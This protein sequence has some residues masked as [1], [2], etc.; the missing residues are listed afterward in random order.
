MATSDTHD[1]LLLP[2][3]LCNDAVWSEQVRLL[4]SLRCHIPDYGK[5]DSIKAMAE[6]VLNQA[7]ARFLLAGHSMGGRVALEIY[8]QAP[9]RV[10]RLILLDTGFRSRPTDETGEREERARMALLGQAREQGMR[11]MGTAWLQGMVHP[12]RLSDEPLLASILNMIESKTPS[13]FAAQIQALLTRPEATPVLKNIQCPTLLICGRQDS[14]S[15]LSR[16]EEMAHLIPDS[17]LVVIEEAGHMSPMERPIEVASAIQN[18]LTE[19][20]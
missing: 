4:P 20:Q 3:L 8:R 14:W 10:S 1:L 16:H 18:W 11:A 15:P 5:A 6:L 2:G 12:E 19:K 7:P 17:H 9:E 13:I